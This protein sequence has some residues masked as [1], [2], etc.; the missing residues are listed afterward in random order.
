[1]RIRSIPC[2][3][4]GIVVLATL[5]VQAIP[6]DESNF[7]TH[8]DHQA[9]VFWIYGPD[10]QLARDEIEKIYIELVLANIHPDISQIWAHYLQV[11]MPEERVAYL[12]KMLSLLIAFQRQQQKINLQDRLRLRFSDLN[13][14]VSDQDS[15]LVQAARREGSL[16]ALTLSVR[17]YHPHY[18]QLR[19]EITHLVDLAQ[20][21]NWPVLS[22]QVFTHGMQDAQ[23]Q[24][25]KWMLSQLG[26]F[27]LDASND[28]YDD[29]LQQAVKNFQ[30]RHG[31]E[32]TGVIQEKTKK[33]LELHPIQ[34]AQILARNI[35]RQTDLPV[36]QDESYV[37]VNIPEFRLRL[38]KSKQELWSSRV[39]VGRI[40][41]PTP[42]MYSH[43]DNI[44]L[45]PPWYVPRRIARYDLLPKIEENPDFLKNQ[46]FEV[47]DAFGNEIALDSKRKIKKAISED[48]PYFLRQRPGEKNA[49]GRYKFFAPNTR[50]VYLHDTPAVQLF[51]KR[52][53]TFSSGCVRVE[54]AS[55]L[56]KMLLAHDQQ[57]MTLDEST[58]ETTELALLTPVPVFL[59]YW[60]SWIDD[61]SRLQF[62]DDIYNLDQIIHKNDVSVMLD[63]LKII[64]P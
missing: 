26:D 24:T 7:S 13:L 41:R 33:W 1:M 15:A 8:Q 10:G 4:G 20:R 19:S 56:A 50:S 40:S 9:V 57:S 37:L 46:G 28:V 47:F 17:P 12:E 43:I 52:K 45:N 32:P 61:N 30:Q 60:T 27:H 35:Y 42:V 54:H 58:Q 48:F 29:Y 51:E 18:E 63:A 64:V 6:P 55:T 14:N 11:K 39:I 21:K 34:R 62:R 49:L 53:R 23:V 3:V 25:I 5:Q 38:L 59:V 22:D 16:Y 31:L 44:V 36:F 2:L